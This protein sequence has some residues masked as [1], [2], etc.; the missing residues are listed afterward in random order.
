MTTCE[1]KTNC[2]ITAVTGDPKRSASALEHGERLD[3]L[4]TNEVHKVDI[5]SI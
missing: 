1:R 3:V 4:E 2:W 5:G